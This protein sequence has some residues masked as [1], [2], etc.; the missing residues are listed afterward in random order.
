M[1]I[2]DHGNLFK[3]QG[4]LTHIYNDNF[5]REQAALR[6]PLAHEEFSELGTN[7]FNKYLPVL[8]LGPS[9]R[10]VNEKWIC[11]ETILTFIIK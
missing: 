5:P 10:N 4:N 11:Q 1:K 3:F 6:A 7:I 9:Y 2:Y 8:N